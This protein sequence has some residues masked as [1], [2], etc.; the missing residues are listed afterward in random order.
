MQRCIDA[1]GGHQ[2]FDLHRARGPCA[3]ALA[4]AVPAATQT[5]RAGKA[6]RPS[7]ASVVETSHRGDRASAAPAE[8]PFTPYRT[9]SYRHR[10]GHPWRHFLLFT[11]F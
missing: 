2:D 10:P 3:D 4:L 8:V 6:L 9:I 11:K 1:L 5:A 7:G